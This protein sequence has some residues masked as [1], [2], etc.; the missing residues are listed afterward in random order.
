[1]DKYTRSQL[2]RMLKLKLNQIG[3]Y[4]FGLAMCHANTKANLINRILE[5]QTK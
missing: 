1:M 2:T 5:A 4:E 3:H